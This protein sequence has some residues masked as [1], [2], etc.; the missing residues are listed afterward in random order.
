MDG[1]KCPYCMNIDD[2]TLNAAPN[3][4]SHIPHGTETQV[5]MDPNSNNTW[6]ET[7]APAPESEARGFLACLPPRTRYYVYPGKDRVNDILW[8]ESTRQQEGDA[9]V[10]FTPVSEA[11]FMKLGESASGRKDFEQRTNTL[12][13]KMPSLPHELASGAFHAHFL[14]KTVQIG[15]LREVHFLQSTRI[16]STTRSKEADICYGVR[17]R[18]VTATTHSPTVAVEVGWSQTGPKLE[19]DAR[20][21]LNHRGSRVNRVITVDIKRSLRIIITA[22]ERGATPTVQYPDPAPVV[23]ERVSITR[24]TNWREPVL[25]GTQFITV[26]LR[27]LLLREPPE[28]EENFVFSREDILDIADRIWTARMQ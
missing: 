27:Q 15:V 3:P 16:S 8:D 18:P 24:P 9:F 6:S 26:P 21:W 2:G 20:W 22:W 14:E 19:A 11:E 10:V 25:V 4:S 7:G 23:K 13:I 17:E 28:G 5:G 12:I 1:L